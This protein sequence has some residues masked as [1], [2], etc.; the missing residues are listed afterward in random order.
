MKKSRRAPADAADLRRR[1]EERLKKTSGNPKVD[2]T[3]ASET[4]R[5]VHELQVHQIELE[6]QNEELQRARTEL[7]AGLERYT[8]LYDFAPVGYLT[9]GRD[10]AIRKV[11]LTGARLLRLERSR[12]VG[13]RMG[14]FVADGSRAAFDAF[15]GRVFESQ[16]KQVCQVALLAEDGDTLSVHVE[17]T[18]SEDGQECRAVLLDM[19]EQQ[20]LEDTM[21]FRMVL[22][23][24]A[25]THSLEELIQKTLD[26][27]GALTSSPIGFYHFVE[28]DQTTL[29]LQAWSTRTVN[30]FCT[31][32]GQ[33]RHYPLDQAG[34]WADCVR[35]RRSLIHNDYPSLPNR[36]GLPEG[37]AAVT[38]E[39]VVPIMRHDRIVA[40]AGVGNKPSDYTNGDVEIVSFLADLAWAMIERKRAEEALRRSEHL[41]RNLFESMDEGFVLCEIILDEAGRPVDW[42]YL[43]ANPAFARLTGLPVEGVIGRTV[44][45]VLPGIETRWIEAFGRVAQGG[46]PERI[47]NRVEELGRE[48]EAHVWNTGAGRFAVVFSDTTERKRAEEA[49]KESEQRARQAAEALRE[50]DRN[51][52]Q[53]LAMLSHELRNPLAPMR[54]SL[55]VLDRTAPGSEQAQRARAVIDRQVGQ[56]TRL[57]DDL[58][59]VTRISRGKVHLES[60]RL[61]LREVVIRAA[62]DHRSAFAAHG[63]EMEVLVPDDTVHVEGDRTRLMQ[64]VGNLLN[65]AAKFTPRGSQTRIVLH[66]DAVAAEAVIRVRDTGAGISADVLPRVFDAFVQAEH[67]LDRSRSGLGLGLA[68]VKGI[69]EM[70][71]GSVSAHSEGLGKGA[72]FTIRLPLAEGTPAAAT[73]ADR[74]AKSPTLRRVL[75]IEDDVDAAESLREALEFGEHEVAVARDGAEGI[76]RAREL[77]PHLVLCD[78]GLPGINGYEV[79][80]AFRS[81]EALRSTCLVALTGYSAPPED[82]AKS[83]EAGFDHHIAKPPSIQKLEE[84]LNS[85]PSRPGDGD[86]T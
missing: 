44:K 36:K 53:F 25:P 58:L 81:E 8:D 74:E 38:R 52:N 41:F 57:I 47:E 16:A 40:V 31:A 37:H 82:V 77:R 45:E 54:S 4:Q 83:R 11:N 55:Y 69:V 78:I 39:L 35:E 34:V 70:H 61:D 26:H 5:F 27:L 15:L 72:E 62:E 10:G 14:L 65:N 18:A 67:T 29:S 30:E 59:D 85:L 24:F 76:R 9:L 60:E 2:H 56:L 50:A 71:G 84:I 86:G 1:A 12:L 23:D 68:L 80:R 43:N 17:A 28:P 79:A 49:I 42:R 46:G 64:V 7:E 32:E 73:A 3:A 22:L 6:L 19:T 21:H 13:R 20:R 33:G 66:R 75:V 63:L 48:F 51:K